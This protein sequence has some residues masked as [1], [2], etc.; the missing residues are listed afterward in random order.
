MSKKE[1]KA[2]TT[3]RIGLSDED[4]RFIQR[5]RVALIDT[6]KEIFRCLRI[7]VELNQDGE[8]MDENDKV[9]LC[10]LTEKW[11]SR[12]S[13]QLNRQNPKTLKEHQDE[14]V[15]EVIQQVENMLS[16]YLP[17]CQVK[18]LEKLQGR[19]PVSDR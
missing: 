4:S 10:G 1:N 13:P 12:Y 18:V 8:F 15:E 9:F 5:Q 2:A 16:G 19:L 7:I 6:R 17:K 14:V 3:V 11:V